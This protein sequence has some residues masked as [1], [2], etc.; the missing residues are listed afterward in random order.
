MAPRNELVTKIIIQL[1]LR[2]R[3]ARV[4]AMLLTQDRLTIA[5]AEKE[6]GSDKLRDLIWLLRTAMPG[7][8]AINV[9]RKF[10]YFLRSTEK[11]RI[12]ELLGDE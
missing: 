4:L 11:H 8:V 9:R 3:L 1:D 5:E 6:L 7:G 10:G 12:M 2:P